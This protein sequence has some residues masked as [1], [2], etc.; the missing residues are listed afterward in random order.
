[1]IRI[2]PEL[3]NNN[4]VS[5]RLMKTPNAARK[6]MK[7]TMNELKRRAPVKV[8]QSVTDVYNIAQAYVKPGG[9]KR[10]A[11]RGAVSV[12]G[13]TIADLTLVY[14][15]SPLTPSRFNMSPKEAPGGGKKYTV[16]A[17]IKKG[18]RTVIGHWSKPYSEGGAYSRPAK[19][20]YFLAY[21]NGGS[22]L[23]LQRQGNG[24]TKAFKTVSIPQMVGNDE[25]ASH[26]LQEIGDLAE[27]RLEHNLSRMLGR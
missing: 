12:Q 7:T 14:T 18:N 26:A 27:E 21:G 22:S 2:V 25:V 11:G 17:A 19:S 8:A 1:M 24:K 9:K 5:K 4:D 10:M 3:M 15:G 13:E 20:P 6:A 23:L 16:K